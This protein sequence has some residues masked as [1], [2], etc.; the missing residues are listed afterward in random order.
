MLKVVHI[1]LA[2]ALLV[3]GAGT[4]QALDQSQ[5]AHA[6]HASQMQAPPASAQAPA[7]VE[8]PG[9]AAAL[10]MTEIPGK[11]TTERVCA[12]CHSLE[13]ALGVR[14][15][16]DEWNQVI[17]RMMANGLTASDDELYE[18]SDYLGANY[19]PLPPEP[20]VAAPASS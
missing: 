2:A 11:A 14:R 3:G 16:P 6:H 15:S 4:V 13:L 5:D 17:E 10:Q 1:A 9:T 19:A 8:D 20:A 18:M 7:Q 12:Q